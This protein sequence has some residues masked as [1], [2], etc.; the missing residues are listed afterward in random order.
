M[1]ITM[2]GSLANLTRA[3]RLQVDSKIGMDQIVLHW[4]ECE[5]AHSV[6]GW[7]AY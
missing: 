6:V 7:D 4:V 1:M 3:G 5:N 2:M